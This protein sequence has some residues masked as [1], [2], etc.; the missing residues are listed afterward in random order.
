MASF[1]FYFFILEYNNENKR[2]IR[3]LL[4][5]KIAYIFRSNDNERKGYFKMHCVILSSFNMFFFCFFYIFLMNKIFSEKCFSLCSAKRNSIFSRFRNFVSFCWCLCY[6]YLP[7]YY[8][9]GNILPFWN[10]NIIL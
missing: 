4:A 2:F 9:I 8:C 5:N 10:V 7:M 1:Y 6:L 3:L